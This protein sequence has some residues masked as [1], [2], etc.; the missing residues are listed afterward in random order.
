[1]AISTI[2]ACNTVKV[3]VQ[4]KLPSLFAEIHDLDLIAEEFKYY[5]CSYSS[6]TF[7][8]TDSTTTSVET[9]KAMRETNFDAVKNFIPL[10]VI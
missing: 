7:G 4:N 3:A 9:S 5:R 2:N 1:M 8:F 10:N 6:F